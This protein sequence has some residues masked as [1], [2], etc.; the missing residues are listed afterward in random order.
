MRY[1]LE[2]PVDHSAV[3]PS[4]SGNSSSLPPSRHFGQLGAAAFALTCVAIL[5]WPRCCARTVVGA[6]TAPSVLAPSCDAS[7]TDGAA[8][9]ATLARPPRQDV[10]R[11]RLIVLFR[12]TPYWPSESTHKPNARVST[13]FTYTYM[14]CRSSNSRHCCCP[15]MAA[16]G[17][18]TP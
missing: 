12:S 3:H 4:R 1:S 17:P 8:A 7:R 15:R 2:N 16:V 14:R 6:A 13:A 5:G 11:V 18:S 9:A 10:R